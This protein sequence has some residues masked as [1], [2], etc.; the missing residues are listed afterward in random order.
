[1]YRHLV[2]TGGDSGD[3]VVFA[4]LFLSPLRAEVVTG[5][6]AGIRRAVEIAR[7]ILLDRPGSA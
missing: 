5:G 4:A 6:D 7:R 1:M 2:V 3:T